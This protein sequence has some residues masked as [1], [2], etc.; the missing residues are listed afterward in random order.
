MSKII[1]KNFFSYIFIGFST[2]L[3]NVGIF[4]F[5]FN[6][7]NLDSIFSLIIAS[8]IATLLNLILNKKYTFKSKRKLKD[9]NLI[10]FYLI[11]YF[12]AFLPKKL[13]FDFLF[14]KLKIISFLAYS[15]S[16]I[17]GSLFFYTWQ[18]KIVFAK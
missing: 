2:N 5:F 4:E 12:L 14:L 7:L 3:L 13:V 9:P 18:K 10:L 16:I 8:S 15:I 17:F 1:S 11:G 6:Y